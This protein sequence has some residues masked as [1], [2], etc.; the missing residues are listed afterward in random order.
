MSLRHC[1]K[2]LS[3]KRRRTVSREM[4]ACSVRRTSSPA[5]SSSVQAL[6]YQHVPPSLW[7]PNAVENHGNFLVSLMLKGVRF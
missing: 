2:S 6:S 4:L 3:A 5:K 7:T 1:F